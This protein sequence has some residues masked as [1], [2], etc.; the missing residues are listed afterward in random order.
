MKEDLRRLLEAVATGE[1]SPEE[2]LERLSFFPYEDLGFARLDHHRAL[3]KHFPEVIYGAGKTYEELEVIVDRFFKRAAPLLVTRVDPQS[4]QRLKVRFQALKYYAR[5]R[6]LAYDPTP[7]EKVGRLLILAGGTSDLPVVEEAQVVAEYLGNYVEVICDVG[8]AGVHRLIAEL[9]RLRQARVLI[10]V[11]G[12]EGALPSLVA[13][14]VERPVIAVPTSVGY[15]A[16]F[17]G[18]APLLAMLNSCA[19][20]VGVVNIDNGFGA[21]YLASLI[22]QGPRN[23]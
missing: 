15:G 19:P 22:N 5:G 17:G 8:V 1:L 14:L 4:A 13:G 10:V 20:G 21:A 6:V 7:R 9:P 11:A 23:S 18:L 16:H 12:M 2:A 3:R